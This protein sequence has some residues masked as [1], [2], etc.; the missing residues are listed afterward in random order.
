M[1]LKPSSSCSRLIS[2]RSCSRSDRSSADSGSS[3]SSIA[4]LHRDRAGERHA[5]LLAARELGRIAL[6]EAGEPDDIER[7]ADPLRA[8]SAW[9]TSRMRKP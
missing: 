3:N 7:L 8:I 1:A 4:G 6:L 2:A 9:R 5:L